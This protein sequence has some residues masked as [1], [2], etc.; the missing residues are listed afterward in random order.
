M[1]IDNIKGVQKC[2]IVFLIGQ[3]WPPEVNDKYCNSNNVY[4]TEP[5][6]IE[7]QDLC[8]WEENCV[9]ISFTDREGFDDVCYVCLV[10]IGMPYRLVWVCS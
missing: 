7:C 2:T 5:D 8:E 1:S 6:R 9:G 4:H 10:C 3:P